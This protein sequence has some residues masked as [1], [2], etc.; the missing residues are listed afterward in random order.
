MLWLEFL[1]AFSRALFYLRHRQYLPCCRYRGMIPVRNSSLRPVR[2]PP[3]CWQAY[4]EESGA[5]ILQATHLRRDCLRHDP[6]LDEGP[7]L[8]EAATHILKLRK[9]IS[10]EDARGDHRT[11]STRAMDEI[12]CILIQFVET[13]FEFAER[14]INRAFDMT[15]HEL[16]RIANV[17]DSNIFVCSIGKF[18]RIDR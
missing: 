5:F 16:A 4:S 3:P 17:E 10:F 14:N 1:S 11:I 9:S 7:H 12:R 2:S 13:R 15:V 6:V 8:R 18:M